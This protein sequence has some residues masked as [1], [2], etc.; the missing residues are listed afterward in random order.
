MEQHLSG[1]HDGARHFPTKGLMRRIFR[2]R[3]PATLSNRVAVFL[4]S[5]NG[6]DRLPR[7]RQLKTHGGH[8]KTAWARTI[9]RLLVVLMAWTPYQVA[10]AA[11]IGTDQVATSSSSADRGAL[12][13]LIHRTD[14]PSPLQALRLDPAPA[15]NR[16]AARPGAPGGPPREDV[17]PRPRAAPAVREDD[18]PAA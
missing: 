7:G 10:Q 11:M 14:V 1:F 17:R 5:P 16:G 8:M 3:P 15:N 12:L 2:C 6:A 4:T 18:G 13:S 9:C